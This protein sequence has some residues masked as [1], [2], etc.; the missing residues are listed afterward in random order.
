MTTPLNVSNMAIYGDPVLHYY[1]DLNVNLGV[2]TE[3]LCLK[4]L[5]EF[6]IKFTLWLTGVGV[7][8]Y[9]EGVKR[10]HFVVFP[11]K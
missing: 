6:A 1:F 10:L 7:V 8:S 3:H 9:G 2:V 11:N 5:L 4:Y